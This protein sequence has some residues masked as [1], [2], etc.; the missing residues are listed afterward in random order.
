AELLGRM[1]RRVVGTSDDGEPYRALDAD[2]LLWVWATL[3]DTALLVYERV[4]P[5][6]G[7]HDRGQYYDEWK[8]VAHACGVPEG[9]CPSTWDD[10]QAYLAGVVRDELRV[11]P[12]ARAV[13]HATMVPP[14]PRPLDRVAARPQRLVTAGL[15][16]PTVR[17]D[18]G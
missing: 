14:L 6:L 16:P 7:A 9:D 5:P 10:F 3:C 12:S 2:L 13:A 4:R 17:S 18:S 1:H 11:T 15:L 8:L